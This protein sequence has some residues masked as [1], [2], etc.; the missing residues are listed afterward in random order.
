MFLLSRTN[1]GVCRRNLS[2]PTSQ[3]GRLACPRCDSGQTFVR[4]EHLSTDVT[5]SAVLAAVIDRSQ[6][7][8]CEA[9]K[10]MEEN[11]SDFE[12]TAEQVGQQ[13]A[14][15]AQKAGEEASKAFEEAK[16]TFGPGL[17]SFADKLKAGL[18]GES[19]KKQDK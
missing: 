8:D 10:D 11:K 3:R 17:K 2:Y 4:R 9:W 7:L 16:K 13:V 18:K 12:K 1:S 19:E 6:P 15:A 5:I 14:D